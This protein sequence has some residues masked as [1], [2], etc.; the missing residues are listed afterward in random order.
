[1]YRGKA[2]PRLAGRYVYGDYCSGIV[3][4]IPANGKSVRREPVEVPELASFGESLN[5]DVLYAVSR[6]GTIYR[7]AR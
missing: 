5:G 3:W 1:M 6:G 2:V 4:S 7:F